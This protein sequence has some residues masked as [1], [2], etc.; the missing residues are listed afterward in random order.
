MNVHLALRGEAAGKESENGMGRFFSPTNLD[1]YRRLAGDKINATERNRILK[2]LAEEW[3]AFTH[4]CRIALTAMDPEAARFPREDLER[5]D[6]REV[7][8]AERRK[9]R[10]AGRTG[11]R[12]QRRVWWDAE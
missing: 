4:G 1:R 10:M 3:G 8:Y 2:L 12:G 9:V 11:K 5:A 6:Q 7:Y